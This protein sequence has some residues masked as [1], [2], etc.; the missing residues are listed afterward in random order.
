MPRDARVCMQHEIQEAESAVAGN[1][2]PN[3]PSREDLSQE[4][5]AQ[6]LHQAEVILANKRREARLHES[7]C[8]AR[9]SLPFRVADV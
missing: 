4:A 8:T 7:L 3:S 2:N 1:K 9:Q 6:R 5:R